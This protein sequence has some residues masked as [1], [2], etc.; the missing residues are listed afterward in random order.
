MP[1]QYKILFTVGIAMIIIALFIW[2]L[3]PL[4]WFPG[5]VGAVCI[6]RGLYMLMNRK[7][8]LGSNSF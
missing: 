6:S 2:L 1:K 7:P 5:A 4:V 8:T 3:P